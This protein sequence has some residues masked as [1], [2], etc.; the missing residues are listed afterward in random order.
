MLIMSVMISAAIAAALA[1]MGRALG[2]K[3][4]GWVGASAVGFGYAAGHIAAA[5]LAFPP[6]DVTDRIPW[7][8]LAAVMVAVFEA[9]RTPGPVTRWVGRSLL[10]A[11][12]LGLMLGPVVGAEGMVRVSLISGLVAL[13]AWADVE[14]LAS[15]CQT[16]DALRALLITAGGAAVALVIAGSVVLGFLSAVLAAALAGGWLVAMRA[17]PPSGW[18]M[19]ASLV[20]TA[21]VL[22]GSIYASLPAPAALLLAVSPAMAWLTRLGPAR[23]LGR[24]PALAFGTVVVSIPVAIAVAVA[25]ALAPPLEY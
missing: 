21:L 4:G 15:R 16:V 23:R 10:A 8:A 18:V 1:G 7:L 19:A 14:V 22:E 12:M 2:G 24:W 20:L 13:V 5:P 9:V 25:V 3:I 17:D 6:V 11:L